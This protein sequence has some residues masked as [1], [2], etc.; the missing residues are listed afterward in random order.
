MINEIFFGDK[1]ITYNLRYKPVKNINIRIKPDGSITVSASSYISRNIVE[2]FL[3]SK[4]EWIV[5]SLEKYQ[6]K[7]SSPS[8]K[9]REEPELQKMIYDLCAKAYPYYKPW[10]KRYP[11]I[12]FKNTKSRW[13]SCNPTKGI[14]CFSTNLI[15]VPD[16]CVEY[17]VYHEFS[18]FLQPNHSDKFYYE[19]SKVYPQWKQCRQILKNI[20][21]G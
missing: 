9:Y 8:Q 5:K 12:K 6:N 4:G 15:Y 16:D 1:K 21:I 17:V 20:Q 19:L 18:H 2:S 7:K 11:Q 3:I 13:G 10:L 14:L